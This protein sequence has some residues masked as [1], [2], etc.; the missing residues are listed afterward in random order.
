[1]QGDTHECFTLRFQKGGN[2]VENYFVCKD[3]K[4]TWVRVCLSFRIVRPAADLSLSS[5]LFISVCVVCR[6]CCVRSGVRGV[7]QGVPQGPHGG[8]LHAQPQAYV[9]LLLLPQ[10]PQVPDPQRQDQARMMLDHNPP[11]SSGGK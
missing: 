3:C 9:G 10:E 7:R 11:S 8:E 6:V 5:S 1:M 4:I 2:Q